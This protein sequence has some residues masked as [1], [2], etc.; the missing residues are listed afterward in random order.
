MLFFQLRNETLNNPGFQ[1]LVKEK[2]KFDV[3]IFSPVCLDAGLYAAKEIFDSKLIM[4]LPGLRFSFGDSVMGNPLY[5]SHVPNLL[6][7]YSEVM[8]FKERVINVLFSYGFDL[9]YEV[10][11]FPKVSKFIQESFKLPEAPDLHEIAKSTDLYFVNSHPVLDAVRPMNPNTV[12]IG[13]LHTGK[14]L[15]QLPED[16]KKWLDEA[17][18]GV[19][20]V[21]FG[22]V[23]NLSFIC[24]STCYHRFF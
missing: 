6:L 5:L 8:T 23:R 21:S 22:S 10:L 18:E 16:L 15:K 9:L 12:L 2:P 20:Y 11:L 7:P 24:K 1:R 13:G 17:K 14:G 3:T 4:F 19:V